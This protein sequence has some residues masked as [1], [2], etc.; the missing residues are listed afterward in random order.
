M[1]NL[2]VHGYEKATYSDA[3]IAVELQTWYQL[4]DPDVTADS[5]VGNLSLHL[6]R[7]ALKYIPMERP[8]QIDCS[9]ANIM[10]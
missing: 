5:G 1:R 10:E 3:T 9:N 2:T 4:D 6:S 8:A 7:Y